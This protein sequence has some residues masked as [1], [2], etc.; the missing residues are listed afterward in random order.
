MKGLAKNTVN[1]NV[2]PSQNFETCLSSITFLPA[3]TTMQ[4]VIL[5]LL[6]SFRKYSYE[7]I[8][9]FLFNDPD[10]HLIHIP[11]F[12]TFSEYKQLIVAF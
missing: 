9:N 7:N 12:H 1:A 2:L 11:Q 5:M 8:S 10:K 3:K 4:N 6:N